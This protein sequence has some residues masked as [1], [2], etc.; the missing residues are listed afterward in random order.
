MVV[1]WWRACDGVAIANERTLYWSVYRQTLVSV[2]ITDLCILCLWFYF[3]STGCTRIA[4]QCAY[5]DNLLTMLYDFSH[6]IIGIDA[7]ILACWDSFQIA[8]G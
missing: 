1:D 8:V 7:P 3:H 2:Y 4:N 6:H 5:L